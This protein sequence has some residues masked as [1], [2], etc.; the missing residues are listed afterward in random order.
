MAA[1]AVRLNDR[2]VSLSRDGGMIDL[3]PSH[4]SLPQVN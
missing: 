2:T 3:P 4:D 1:V